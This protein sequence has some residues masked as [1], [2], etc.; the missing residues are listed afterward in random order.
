MAGG[1]VTVKYVDENGNEVATPEILTGN[2][3]NDY[4]TKEKHVDGY[5]F[6]EV[7]GN[8][9]GKF[10]EEAQTVTYVYTK[11]NINVPDNPKKDDGTNVPDNPEKDDGTN[12]SDNPE[13]DDGTNVSDK[14]KKDDRTNLPD[15]S[16][17]DDRTNL[18]DNSK[19]DDGT[20]LTNDSKRNKKNPVHKI[21]E[22]FNKKLPATGSE[23]GIGLSLL[24]FLLLTIASLVYVKSKHK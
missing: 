19:K 21:I 12:V 10:S 3:G 2:I 8:K 17:K 23:M 7:Q 5:T 14:S 13:K 16:K 4:E 11:N 22:E 18:P 20:N 15:N 9:L 6:K 24:G 1:K